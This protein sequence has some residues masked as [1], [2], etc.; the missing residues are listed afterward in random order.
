MNIQILSKKGYGPSEKQKFDGCACGN[1]TLC[2]KMVV[3]Q[4]RSRGRTD[5]KI[6]DFVGSILFILYEWGLNKKLSNPGSEA[7][8]FN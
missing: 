6:T 7:A 2:S 4:F 5:K 1:N 8:R 3:F